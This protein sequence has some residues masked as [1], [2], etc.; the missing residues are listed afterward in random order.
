MSGFMGSVV[1][2][3]GLLATVAIVSAVLSPK[4]TTAKVIGAGFSGFTSGLSVALS[5]ITGGSNFGSPA[6]AYQS[7]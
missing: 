5:P 2:I 6:S 7:F 4:A 3:L 1:A